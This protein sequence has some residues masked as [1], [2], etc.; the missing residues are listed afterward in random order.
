MSVNEQH[1]SHA[2]TVFHDPSLCNTQQFLDRD[3]ELIRCDES[4]QCEYKR[5]Y[6]KMVICTCPAAKKQ[7]N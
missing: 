4:R 5:Y 2:E 1:G 7:V 6:N 3:V